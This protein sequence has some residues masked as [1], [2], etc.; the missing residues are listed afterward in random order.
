VVGLKLMAHGGPGRGAAIAGFDCGSIN[1][2]DI[3]DWLA[4]K[5]RQE[6]RQQA[7][8]LQRAKIAGWAGIVAA[9]IGALG[10]A[11]AVLHL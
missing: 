3:E 1:R 11:V 4:E 10:I 9:V 7:Q 2:G 5:T 6:E 8:T